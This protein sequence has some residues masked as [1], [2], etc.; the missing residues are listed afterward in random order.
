MKIRELGGKELSYLRW[1]VSRAR[2]LGMNT[3]HIMTADKD[4]DSV[5]NKLDDFFEKKGKE[6]SIYGAKQR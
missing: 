3:T 5:H 4:V 6:A 2:R 1:R